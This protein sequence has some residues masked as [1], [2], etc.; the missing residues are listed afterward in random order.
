MLRFTF[1]LDGIES[2]K[3]YVMLN[4]LREEVRGG[5]AFICMYML[6]YCVVSYVGMKW[7]P[8]YYN[9]HLAKKREREKKGFVQVDDS[10]HLLPFGL[11][12]SILFNSIVVCDLF[13]CRVLLNTNER[14]KKKKHLFGYMYFL[15]F[16]LYTDYTIT[17]HDL[18]TFYC[19]LYCMCVIYR[20]CVV[21][22][23]RDN[24]GMGKFWWYFNMTKGLSFTW[25]SNIFFSL[26][27]SISQRFFL[28]FV[29]VFVCSSSCLLSLILLGLHC[30]F[31][32]KLFTLYFSSWVEEKKLIFTSSPIYFVLVSFFY[33][34]TSLLVRRRRRREAEEILCFFERTAHL[35][36]E[37]R[38]W[39]FLN[40]TILDFGRRVSSSLCL[41]SLVM[42]DDVH[43]LCSLC[44]STAEEEEE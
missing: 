16:P 32:V 44:S 22:R 29:S 30:E 21:C 6:H 1:F 39:R 15:K 33:C 37:Y 17:L 35:T 24:N 12:I 9:F 43:W 8:N 36:Q 41:C 5:N 2:K 25:A 3:D 11:T 42:R 34:W 13:W 19:T 20:C 10:S 38:L 26:S 23:Q 27:L 4:D 7:L 28:L 14:K 40:R 31:N 18:R